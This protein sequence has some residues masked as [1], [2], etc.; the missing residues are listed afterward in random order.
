[1]TEPRPL[2]L[3]ARDARDMDVI[4][5]LLQDALVPLVDMAYLKRD[6]RFVMVAN[7]FLWGEPGADEA[8]HAPEPLP[9]GADASFEDAEE[10]P[11]FHRVHVGIAFDKVLKV[12]SQGFDQKEKDQI[13]NLLTIKAEPK[14]ITLLF[15]EGA[16]VMLEVSEIACHLEDVGETWPT[17]WRPGHG[18]AIETEQQ[19][20]ESPTK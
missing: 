10:E 20:A 3:R 8:Q 5:A 14:R 17:R 6:K 18:D 15:S 12:R 4:A 1:M 2:K 7:R 13:L 9:T 11:P 16:T 19:T